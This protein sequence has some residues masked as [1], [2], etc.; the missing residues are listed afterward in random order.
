MSVPITARLDEE[1]VEA[2]DRA[3]RAGAAPTRAAVVAQAV[4]EWLSRH[5]E[6]AI[7]DSYRRAYAEADPEHDE[8]VARIGGYSAS[9]TTRES[10]R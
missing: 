2:L 10:Q 3:V 7:E 5:S 1:T 8:L 4:E 9:V 6:E